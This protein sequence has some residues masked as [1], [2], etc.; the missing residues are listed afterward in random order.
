MRNNTS[1]RVHVVVGI[2]MNVSFCSN[3]LNPVLT[4]ISKIGRLTDSLLQFSHTL[5]EEGGTYRYHSLFKS[6]SKRP[7]TTTLITALPPFVKNHDEVLR[8]RTSHATGAYPIICTNSIHSVSKQ[9]FHSHNSKRKTKE[10]ET[11]H[12]KFGWK[13]YT[14]IVGI[15]WSGY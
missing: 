4:R 15:R 5:D 1:T 2:I 11:C 3:D 7:P 6:F 14:V 10:K 8:C 9:T 12:S 13:S